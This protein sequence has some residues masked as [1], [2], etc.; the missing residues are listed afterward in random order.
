MADDETTFDDAEL[1]LDLSDTAPEEEDL[2]I[3]LDL[4]GGDE[5]KDID[6]I[7]LNFGADDDEQTEEA[8]APLAS[9][10]D[11][12]AARAELREQLAGQPGDWYVVH[13]YSGMEKRVKQNIDSRVKTL[14]ME[15]FIY[16]T[17]VPTED[18]VEIRNGAKKTVTRTV[19]PGYVLV[20]MELTD[21][22]WSAVRHT[23]SVTG[24]VGRAQDP[25][26]LSL[27]EVI[28]M[29]LPSALAA[30]SEQ[31]G[32]KPARK[33]KVELVDFQIGDS[34]ILTDGPFTGV[35]AT[36]TE[37]NTHTSRLKATLEFMG[38]D[39]PVDLTLDQVQKL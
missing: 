14:N 28:E 31:E 36:I 34:V 3:N 39:T 29:M 4:G 20:R 35:H 8:V 12:D 38:R 7:Q 30:K 37:I 33:K 25:V 21:D 5:P 24:F 10:D 11:A 1:N 32:A 26:P 9:D 27:D 2:Q 23:P 13:T 22:S 19:L 18:V 15:D 16:E 6:D 17:V